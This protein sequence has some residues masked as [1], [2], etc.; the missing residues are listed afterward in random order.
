MSKTY[1]LFE[2]KQKLERLL[3]MAMEALEYC[4]KPDSTHRISRSTET[5]AAIR[6]EISE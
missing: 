6:K 1:E 2:E 5:L 3:K 4:A